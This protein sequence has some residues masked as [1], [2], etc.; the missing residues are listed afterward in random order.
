MNLKLPYQFSNQGLTASVDYNNHIR[1]MIEQILFTGPGERVNR[2]DFGSGL[3]QAV[4]EPTS[5]EMVATTQ[6]LVQSALNQWLGQLII[7]NE[8][9]IEHIDSRLE[10]NVSYTILKSMENQ[11]IKVVNQN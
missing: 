11:I 4:F 7:V 10:V 2:P 3:L 9:R 1:N 6:Y 5:N 8:V